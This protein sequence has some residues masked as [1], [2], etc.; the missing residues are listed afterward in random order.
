MYKFL[1]WFLASTQ[2]KGR[3]CFRK[4]WRSSSIY[5]LRLKTTRFMQLPTTGDL[6]FGAFLRRYCWYASSLRH[7]SEE[8]FSEEVL[9]FFWRVFQFLWC[10]G[11]NI[12]LRIIKFLVTFSI[13]FLDVF[14]STTRD[15]A[16]ASS[17]SRN[18]SFCKSHFQNS[19]ERYHVRYWGWLR[20]HLANSELR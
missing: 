11:Q 10:F 19:W 17:S 6:R 1:F 9:I 2:F 3:T 13:R 4:R 18:T 5:C 20:W 16:T 12:I 14:A 8:I 15:T 7:V